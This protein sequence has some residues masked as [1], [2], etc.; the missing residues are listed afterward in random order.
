[1]LHSVTKPVS[2]KSPKS[3]KVLALVDYDP[4]GLAILSTYKHGSVSLSH[5]KAH[6][7]LPSIQWLGLNSLSLGLHHDL[8]QS[9][10]LLSLSSR[11]RH[12]AINMLTREP[13]DEGGTEP[14]W[15][16]EI[17]VMLYLNIK[18]EI[19]ILDAQDGGTAGW[20]ESHDLNCTTSR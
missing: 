12:K 17:Q 10:G 14:E 8:H 4:D 2:K 18:A 5:E 7:T 20:L 6:L 3:R 13:F 9:Q 15:R 19:Q 1:M 11:D 16:R